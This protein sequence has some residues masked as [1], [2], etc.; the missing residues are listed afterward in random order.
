MLI[1]KCILS[2]PIGVGGEAMF[3]IVSNDI[4]TQPNIKILSGSSI[5]KLTQLKVKINDMLKPPITM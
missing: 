1:V 5:K 3:N 4:A 2:P